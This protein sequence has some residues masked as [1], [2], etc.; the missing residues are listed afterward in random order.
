[1]ND[2]YQLIQ[3][4]LL[5]FLDQMMIGD[6]T[7]QRCILSSCLILRLHCCFKQLSH[8]WTRAQRSIVVLVKHLAKED[9]AYHDQETVGRVLVSVA[10]LTPLGPPVLRDLCASFPEFRREL[11][12]PL[13]DV[14]A[15]DLLL[16]RTSRSIALGCGVL[17]YALGFL[18]D[19]EPS[20]VVSAARTIAALGRSTGKDRAEVAST[21]TYRLLVDVF[22][23]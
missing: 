18:H 9:V 8:Y 11:Q 3:N 1:M 4:Q 17:Q 19:K 20:F 23:R 10:G 13:L 5:F 12:K 7:E 16:S 6:H 14:I 15:A 2:D 22:R 21:S